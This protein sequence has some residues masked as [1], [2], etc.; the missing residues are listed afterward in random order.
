MTI[1][2]VAR[3]ASVSE[4][5][6]SKALNGRGQLREE[7]RERVRVAARDLG[8]RANNLARGLFSGRSFTVGL[9]T[10]DRFGRFS[11]PVLLG[12]EDTLAADQ[13]SVFLCDTRDDPVRERHHVSVMAAHQVDGF[14]VTSRLTDS[15]PPLELAARRPVVYV[16]TR[17]TD[18]AD[19]SIVSDEV[20]GGRLGV[21]Y[22]LA[23]GRRRIAHVTGPE[24]HRSATDRVLGVS[25]ALDDAGV[26]L[27]AGR[28]LHGEWTEEWGRQAAALAVAA[29]PELEAVSCGSDQ[30][31]RGVIDGLR[32]CGRSVPR[33]VAVVGYD[34]WDVM[35]TGRSPALTTVDPQLTDIGRLAGEL[36]LAALG[37]DVRS[38]VHVSTPRLVVRESTG[39]SPT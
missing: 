31:A 17:S 34:D 21:E 37:G 1:T 33:D 16:R 23:S 38:G 20:H 30:V 29:D 6:V 5:T 11:M 22:L 39:A 7:T 9:I 27:V 14:I 19:I 35:A 4:A 13:M 15:R 28:P 18:P 36:L 25:A 3:A 24:R 2:D 8:Y 32:A 12:A 26:P 10:S